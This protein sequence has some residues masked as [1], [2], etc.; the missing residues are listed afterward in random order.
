MRQP[1]LCGRAMNPK[2]VMP[3]SRGICSIRDTVSVGSPPASVTSTEFT[4]MFTMLRLP[5]RETRPPLR[6]VITLALKKKRTGRNRCREG[7][8]Y[9][10]QIRQS[11]CHC[12]GI[13]FV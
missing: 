7:D 3:L 13:S 1:A 8:A 2:V 4:S 9:L 11:R 6:T 10:A 12:A 5:T